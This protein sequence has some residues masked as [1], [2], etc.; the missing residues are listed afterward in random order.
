MHRS[1]LSDEE[2]EAAQGVVPGHPVSEHH[3]EDGDSALLRPACPHGSVFVQT[4]IN[5]LLSHPS[6]A[7]KSQ[8]INLVLEGSL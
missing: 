4:I 6:P 7:V 1:H 5:H 2:T 8:K 3:R